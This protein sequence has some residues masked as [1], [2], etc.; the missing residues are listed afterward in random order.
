M[1]LGKLTAR[2]LLAAL[3]PAVSVVALGPG[4]VPDGSAP[5]LD[6]S[7]GATA[8]VGLA[9]YP[10]SMRPA[11][12][13]PQDDRP[14]FHAGKA[15][16]NQP[17]VKAPTITTARD[18][19]GPIYN[20]RSCLACHINGGRGRLPEGDDVL[21]SAVLRV[22]RR[23]ADPRHGVVRHPIYGDQLQVQSVS[24]AD[25][26][27]MDPAQVGPGA[28]REAPAEAKIRIAWSTSSFTYPDGETI[29]LRVPEAVVDA[30]GYGPLGD[31][32]LRS[33]RVAPSI[34]GSGLLSL[35]ADA[36]L[37]ALADPQD[38]NDDGIS[39]RRNLVW[40]RAEER[41]VP[42]RF[43]WKAGQPDLRHTVAAAFA[44]DLGISS[45]LFPEGPCTSAQPRCLAMARGDDASGVELSDDLLDLVTGF[46]TNLGVPAARPLDPRGH[47]EGGNLFA[48]VGCGACH[49]PSFVTEG[50][51][52]AAHLSMQQIWP[53]SDLLLHDMG[54][55]LADGRTEF[56]A[57]GREW[58]TPPLW[59]IG[60]SEQINGSR[61]FL[62]D[63]RAQ[64]LEEAVLWHG[65]EA[66][67]ARQ[68]FV[69]LPREQRQLLLHFVGSL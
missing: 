51:E 40:S 11:P 44:N 33:L 31:D 36:D 16:A 30:L 66:A 45:P 63:G 5:P 43:G 23:G 7:P 26:L 25:Q 22:S 48:S 29:V 67:E 19:L 8:T 21:S 50:S 24:L 64:T 32:V 54:E 10:S 62:H 69:H 34:H 38:A 56:D 35:I 1:N 18:G 12:S 47:A 57:S 4:V 61:H 2:A 3:V 27:G 41:H 17:W 59:G 46:A 14:E 65:G 20:V 58:R 53:Y 55:A 39:G 6:W 60:L 9:P 15:L 28:E 37:D 49:Q 42:G 68:R 52:Q 13:L